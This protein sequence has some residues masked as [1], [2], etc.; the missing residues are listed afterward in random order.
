MDGS[1][2][3][4][5]NTT[6]GAE[7]SFGCNP[8]FVPST[9]TTATCASNGMWTPNPFSITC[10]CE[11]LSVFRFVCSISSHMVL[12]AFLVSFHLFQLGE[13]GSVL[14]HLEWEV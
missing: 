12:H 11:Y 7:I 1:I 8:M 2:D 14:T 3:P 10:T 9:R 6:E 4:Y 5:Q 13:G